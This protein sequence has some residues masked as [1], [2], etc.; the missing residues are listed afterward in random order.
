M[1]CTSNLRHGLQSLNL[2]C[3]YVTDEIFE[4]IA[5][6]EAAQTLQTLS[7]A[8]SPISELSNGSWIKFSQLKTLNLV[9]NKRLGLSTL[10]QIVQCRTLERLKFT[11]VW[12][13]DPDSCEETF[14]I[15]LSGDAL[16]RLK[17]FE[18]TSWT[19]RN[20]GL[21]FLDTALASRNSDLSVLELL[22]CDFP[23][24]NFD[25]EEYQRMVLRIHTKCPNLKRLVHENATLPLEVETLAEYFSKIENFSNC[26]NWPYEELPELAEAC[27]KLE[28]LPNVFGSGAFDLVQLEPFRALKSIDLSYME[29]Q[30]S[31]ENIN[32]PTGLSDVQLKFSSCPR[33]AQL[34]GLIDSICSNCPNLRRLIIR[35]ND[36]LFKVSHVE[37]LLPRLL[38]LE[39]LSLLSSLGPQHQTPPVIHP[40]YHSTLRVAPVC[41][42]R[43]AVTF[44]AG[45]LPSAKS[46]PLALLDAKT[47]CLTPN[48]DTSMIYQ[49]VGDDWAPVTVLQRS[50]WRISTWDDSSRVFTETTAKMIS[51]LRHLKSVTL[52]E[53]KISPAQASALLADLPLL[54]ELNINVVAQD[55][56]GDFSWVKHPLLGSLRLDYERQ[57]DPTKGQ[58]SCALEAAFIHGAGLPLLRSLS[59]ELISGSAS[60]AVSP[61]RISVSH[62]KR[63]HRFELQG[64]DLYNTTHAVFS[65]VSIFQ[66]PM[67]SSISIGRVP[68]SRISF[69]DMPYLS[70]IEMGSIT[71]K[72][73]ELDVARLDIPLLVEIDCQSS[74]ETP[75]QVAK[76]RRSEKEAAC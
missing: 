21:A 71:L 41:D 55:N 63:L 74:L 66:M 17:E 65:D 2:D 37:K 14:S 30:M 19:D 53:A 25:E 68:L 62:F 29:V 72:D 75:F 3:M 67:L 57:M 73:Y 48:I 15:I 70:S 42:T 26:L 64:G 1:T 35:I 24:A 76:Q 33:D 45:Y 13:Q 56:V 59:V 60:L 20:D 69:F 36:G 40:V 10:R 11:S 46:V 47:H 6:S 49:P 52:L 7:I 22:Q 39:A 5:S 51:T 54:A 28:E 8:D 4:S 44:T 31:R 61:A 18:Y 27:P 32:L 16:P 34:D 9:N 43:E 58:V 12:D 38:A 50:G 23:N